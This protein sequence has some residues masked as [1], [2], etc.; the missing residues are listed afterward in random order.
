MQ[1]IIKLFPNAALL[2]IPGLNSSN[3]KVPK[4]QKVIS[5]SFFQMSDG[6]VI[7]HVLLHCPVTR[8]VT[9]SFNGYL[10]KLSFCPNAALRE[11]IFILSISIICLRQNFYT[12][13]DF[14][15]KS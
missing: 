8:Q 1:T 4:F 7:G 9:F 5:Y 14:E 12:R 11:K 2:K 13:L 6:K 10:E 15:P 3:S